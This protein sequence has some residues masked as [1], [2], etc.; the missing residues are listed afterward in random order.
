M[1]SWRRRLHSPE[2]SCRLYLSRHGSRVVARRGRRGGKGARREAWKGDEERGTRG[3]GTRGRGVRTC[4]RTWV[5][6][7]EVA[8]G[9][10]T[11]RVTE[12]DVMRHRAVL[13]QHD[14]SLP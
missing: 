9:R 5:R 3:E 4:V 8:R 11:C 13:G 7:G 10:G 1:W 6:G 2:E 14:A 12:V